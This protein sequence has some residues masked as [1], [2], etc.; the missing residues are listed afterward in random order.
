MP[1]K[2]RPARQRQAKLD[3]K[4]K[5]K[6]Q[7]RTLPQAGSPAVPEAVPAFG[8][9]AAKA[10]L[11]GGLAN[12]D[13]G[14]G[15][16]NPVQANKARILAAANGT[17]K[18]NIAAVGAM[19][20]KAPVKP[21]DAADANEGPDAYPPPP[22]VCCMIF[23]GFC[24]GSRQYGLETPMHQLQVSVGSSPVYIPEKKLGKGGFGQVCSHGGDTVPIMLMHQIISNCIICFVSHARPPP[25]RYSRSGWVAG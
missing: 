19:A 21:A 9:L 4:A 16:G 11:G 17:A 18:D 10:G 20:A 5:I 22:K 1:E 24:F 23:W 13:A 3:A 12:V 8:A 25:W 15:L 2:G 7:A 6:E 14:K